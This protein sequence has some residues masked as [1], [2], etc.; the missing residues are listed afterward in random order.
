MSSQSKEIHLKECPFCGGSGNF[1][2]A[3]GDVGVRF[4]VE[5]LLCR[6]ASGDS[7]SKYLAAEAWNRRE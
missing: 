5:C 4:W 7:R 2:K 3:H 1:R 6:A